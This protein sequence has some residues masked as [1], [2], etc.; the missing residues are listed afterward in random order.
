MSVRGWFRGRTSLVAAMT[1]VMAFAGFSLVWIPLTDRAVGWLIQDREL[2]VRVA[3]YKGLL[4][5]LVAA[6]L[7]FWLTFTALELKGAEAARAPSRG[8]GERRLTAWVPVLLIAGSALLLEGVAYAAYRFQDGFLQRDSHQQLLYLARSKAGRIDGWLRERLGDATVLS[9]DPAFQAQVR[10]W[11]EGERSPRLRQDLHGQMEVVRLAYGY[12]ALF[13]L[14]PDGTLTAAS[15]GPEPDAWERGLAGR[16]DGR[17]GPELA[18][19]PADGVPYGT[20]LRMDCLAPVRAPDTGRVLGTLVFRLDPKV[21]LGP[22]GSIGGWPTASPSGDTLLLAR[23]RNEGYIL[24][25]PKGSAGGLIHRPL[26]RRDL[27]GVQSLLEGDGVHQGRDFREVPSVAASWGLQTLPWVVMVKLDR[28]EYLQPVRKLV[29]I[30]SGLGVLFL[31]VTAAFISAWYRRERAEFNRLE[32]DSRTLGM[33]IR[34]L[35]EYSNEII[36]MMDDLGVIL[37]AND[38]AATA[39]QRPVEDLR[40]RH[41]LSLRAPELRGDFPNQFSKAQ[42]EGAVRFRTVHLRRDGST[43]PVEVS[44]YAFE[45]RGRHLVR[46]II[47]DLTAQHEHEQRIQSLNEELE[48]RVQERTAQ[49][50]TALR[51]MES[52]SYSVS[53]DL[54]QPLRGIDGFSLALVQDYGERLDATGRHYLQRIRSGAQRMGQI[55]DDLLDLARLSRLR[56]EPGPVDLSA[57]AREVLAELAEQDGSGRQVET[58][59]QEGLEARAD[60]RLIRIVLLQLLSNAWKFTASRPGARIEISGGPDPEGGVTFQV[61]DNGVGFDM[62]YAEKLFG[63]FQRLHDVGEFPGT[64]VGLAIAHRVVLRHG[65]RIWAMA[66]PGRGATFYFNLPE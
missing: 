38:V 11:L 8:R 20:L 4:Y 21:F 41:V 50:E 60:A 28:D 6:G 32:A 54:R 18:W 43:F 17:H 58:A 51:E 57:L 48:R 3:T 5:V 63:A 7:V 19:A 31:L 24:N 35:S 1:V 55:M 2:M 37:E 16:L 40:G 59:V 44:S 25:H 13:L 10:R 45:L 33:Q 42:A 47:R 22:D 23:H 34:L 46:S 66:E 49:L 29:W 12:P 65:G 14:A 15:G 9:Q 27:V 26:A 53:H 39:Y 62:A 30:Y 61:R 36:L 56:L 64:G 52:F